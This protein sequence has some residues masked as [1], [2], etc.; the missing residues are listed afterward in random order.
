MSVKG[1]GGTWQEQ[2]FLLVRGFG[3]AGSCNK[4][5]SPVPSSCSTH[6][7]AAFPAIPL[8][9]ATRFFGTLQRRFPAGSTEGSLQQLLCHSVSH[10]HALS[11]KVWILVPGGRKGRLLRQSPQPGGW[12]M[13]ICGSPV[14]SRGLSL[15]ANLSLFQS[16]VKVNNSLD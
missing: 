2:C 4:V 3:S 14:F 8:P 9:L 1:V 12:A 10:S 11:N 6:H 5:A 16:S 7:P 15:L 13:L